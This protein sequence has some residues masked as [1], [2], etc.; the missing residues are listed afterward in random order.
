MKPRSFSQF[1][2]VFAVSLSMLLLYILSAANS[3]QAAETQQIQSKA[4]T[5]ELEQAYRKATQDWEYV[6]NHYVDDEG[7]TDFKGLSQD[8][9]PLENVIAF[10]SLV[11]P[12]KTPE[13][14][15]SPQAVMAYH[16]NTY[17]A[18]AMHGV[19]DKDIPDGFTS[20]FS[21]AAF[22]KF[23]DVVIGGK[24][25]NLYDY[26][27]HVIR[28]LNEPRAHFALNCMVKDCPRL[29]QQ[30]FYS[31][32]LEDALEQATYEFFSKEKH[33]YLD[34][35]RKRVYVSEILDFY[36]DDFVPS[37]KTRDLPEYI[38]RYLETPI[39]DGYKLRFIDYDWRIN[40]QP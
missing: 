8:M 28:P 10:I 37:G 35:K 9:K 6:L 32:T 34:D 3:S 12:D 29:P 25:T 38:N 14:F 27:N 7:R 2:N 11:S 30:P 36:T 17:N 15:S 33:F 31:D 40:A 1:K 26:E 19:I 4:E 13:L 18:L 20:F 22:F 5:A 39:P 16:I 23:R 21:R 24:V